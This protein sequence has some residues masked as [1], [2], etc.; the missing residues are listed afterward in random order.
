MIKAIIIDDEKHCIITM[1]H[2]LAKTGEVE[3]LASVQN[4]LEAEEKIRSLQPEIVFI[5][6]Q[7]PNLDGFEVL[8]KFE[9][10]PFKVVFTTAF[11]QYAIKALKMNALDYLQKPISIEDIHEVLEKYKQ[12]ES[13]Q[14]KEQISHVYEFSKG[15][16]LDTIALSVQQG[17][18]FVKID[19]IMYIEGDGCYSHIIMQDQTKHLASKT[20]SVFEEVLSENPLFFRAHKSHLVNIRYIKQYIRGEGGEII[21]KDGKNI[22]ISRNKKQEFLALF[23]RI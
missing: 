2:L 20:I 15:K 21:M 6:I 22:A 9:K 14:T 17:L 18:L 16:V 5:D 7:M 3:I 13:H 19:D 4:S 8:N 10:L 11:D 1:E 23:Q 12:E